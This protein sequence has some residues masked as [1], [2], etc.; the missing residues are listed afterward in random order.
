MQRRAISPEDERHPLRLALHSAETSLGVHEEV[1]AEAGDRKGGVLR[2]GHLD[3]EALPVVAVVGLLAGG[4][5]GGRHQVQQ[6]RGGGR[7][8]VLGGGGGGGPGEGGGEYHGGR[9]GSRNK[10]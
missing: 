9:C 2:A 1:V 5:V 6:N 8:A 7:L 4:D 10:E 3:E